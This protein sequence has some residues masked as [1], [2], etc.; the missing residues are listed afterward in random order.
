MTKREIVDF[1]TFKDNFVDKKGGYYPVYAAVNTYVEE[2]SSVEIDMICEWRLADGKIKFVEVPFK[3][4]DEL[5]VILAYLKT[6]ANLL[7]ESILENIEKIS[8]K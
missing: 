4:F 3:N 7:Y 8:P 2:N 6:G 1:A 5:G